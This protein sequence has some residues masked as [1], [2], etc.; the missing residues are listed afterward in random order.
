MN[1]TKCKKNNT[2]PNIYKNIFLDILQKYHDRKQIYIDAP[3]SPGS[4]GIAIVAENIIISYKLP[5]E[6][7]N[8]T[9]EALAIYNAVLYILQN[10]ETIPNNY[11]VIS[12]SIGSIT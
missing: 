3:K 6:C 8:Y 4:T 2:N 5:T 9:P 1:I 11:L 10:I 7:S 12:Y